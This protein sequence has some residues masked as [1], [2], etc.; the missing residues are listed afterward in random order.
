MKSQ[1]APGIRG[2]PRHG[3]H[4][5]DTECSAEVSSALRSS[6]LFQSFLHRERSRNRLGWNW[7]PVQGVKW[8]GVL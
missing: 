4:L 8:G 6:A 5:V 3:R 1:E 2:F 7:G